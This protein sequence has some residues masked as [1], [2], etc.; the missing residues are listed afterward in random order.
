VRD[1]TFGV[2]YYIKGNNAKIQVNVVR[3]NGGSDLTSAN[4]F[5]S[6]AAVRTRKASPTTGRNCACR[7][8]R[9]LNIQKRAFEYSNARFC[10]CR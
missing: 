10:F 1:L 2:N 9:V 6:G 4:G 3:R 7:P 5:G 8:G